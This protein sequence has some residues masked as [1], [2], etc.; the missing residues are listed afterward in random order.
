MQT[1]FFIKLLSVALFFVSFLTLS[2]SSLASTVISKPVAESIDIRQ[3]TQKEEELWRTE[4]KKLNLELDE[5]VKLAD[6]LHKQKE[7]LTTR[8]QMISMRI[9]EKERQ[10]TEIEK[11]Q[12]NI[13]P[14]IAGIIDELQKRIEN[15]LPFL[16][17]ERHSRIEKLM[18]LR[19]DPE[20]TVSEK[21]RKVLEAMLVETEYGNTVEMYQKSIDINDTETLVNIFRFGRIV[22]FYQTLDMKSC[23]FYNVATGHWDP[24]SP[25]YNRSIIAAMDIGAKRR[26]V[27]LLTLPLGRI[28]L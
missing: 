14:L 22:L 19:D 23:G 11:I 10:L 25:S 18:K 6:Q 21:L 7:N 15:D 16:L 3:S 24:L 26:P 8:K 20:V 5:L 2:D 4:K 28:G 1:H 9:S 17:P 12:K 27:E 13:A